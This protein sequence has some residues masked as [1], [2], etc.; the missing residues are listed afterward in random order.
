MA[1]SRRN[2][3]QRAGIAGLA[4]AA[5]LQA[6]YARSAAG[7][8]IE[9]AGFG[10]LVPDPQGVLDLPKGFRYTVF[11]QVGETMSDGT[12]VPANHDGMAAFAGPGGTTILVRN[13]ELSPLVYNPVEAPEDKKYDSLCKGGTT[14]LVV[15]ADRRLLN[16]YVSLA[17]TYW[18]CAGGP[19]P[20]GSWIS[21]EET[22]AT[23]ARNELV[24]VAHGYAFEVPILA[25]GPV[26]PVPL[27]A[28]GRF[29]HEAA[30]VDPKT[31]IVYM[32]EDM[33]TGLFYRFVPKQPGQLRAGGTLEALRIPSM[34]KAF[35]GKDFP[36]NRPMAVDW[37]TIEDFDPVDDTVRVEGFDKGAAIFAGGEGACFA[38]GEVFFSASDGGSAELG[39]I[40]RYTPGRNAGEGGTIELFV[41]PNDDALLDG[42]DNIVLAPFGDLFV[43]EDGDGTQF[44][45]G[46]TPEGKLYSF[47]RNALNGFE[48]TGASFSPDGKTFFV[49]IQIP[50]M[51]FAIWGPWSR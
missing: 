32:T 35:T 38:R 7:Q 34:P 22:V 37:V 20:W 43:C 44:V 9:G 50:G 39:Q 42:P 51:T 19:T 10:P 5:P 45:R 3:L 49:N 41:E 15:S 29:T 28:M 21:C 6:L 17:G 33:D 36:L 31:G 18:N 12:P 2:F 30:V 23:P 46:I 11:S 24:S 40:W 47:A 14:T 13:H 25:K 48:F 27:K 4:A 1:F 26:D 8:S 16:H